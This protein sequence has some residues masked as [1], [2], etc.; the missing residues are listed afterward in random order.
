MNRE[1]WELESNG[2][3]FNGVAIHTRIEL[4]QVCD[5]TNL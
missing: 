4:T 2:M 1:K 3:E 5:E